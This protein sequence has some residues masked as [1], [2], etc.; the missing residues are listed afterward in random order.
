[1]ITKWFRKKQVKSTIRGMFCN[2][3]SLKPDCKESRDMKNIF[4]LL[5]TLMAIVVLAGCAAT[6]QGKINQAEL[7]C[8]LL[9]S[10]CSRLTPGGKDQVALRYANP[11]AQW[12]NYSKII[13]E[14]VTFWGGDSTPVPTPDQQTLVSYFNQQLN[15]QLAKKF[16]IVQDPGPGVMKIQVAMTDA[17]AATPGLRSVSMIIPQARLLS[18]LKALATDTYPFV[19]G[20]QGELKITDSVTGEVLLEAVDRRIGG[21]SFSTGFQW[22]WGD[23]ENAINAWC[24]KALTRLSSW[25]SGTAS[26]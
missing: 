16:K 3:L 12:T 2:N 10:D 23:A 18:T 17:S 19:G 11:A 6:Q 14:P 8:G 26:P 21:G 5:F 15:E 7:K 25:T 20:A 1:L 4:Y 13:I 24:E 22:K 9:G